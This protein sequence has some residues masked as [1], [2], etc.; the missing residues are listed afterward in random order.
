[1]AMKISQNQNIK[2]PGCGTGG[3]GLDIFSPCIIFPVLWIPCVAI[4]SRIISIEQAP[5]NPMLWICCIGALFFYLAGIFAADVYTAGIKKTARVK[6]A[7]QG[8]WNKDKFLLIMTLWLGAAVACMAYEFKYMVGG[9]PLL[10]RNW[11]IARLY[12]PEGYLS[13]LIHLFGYSFMLHAIAAQVFIYSRP[14]L[15]APGNLP[16]WAMLGADLFCAALWGS[17]HTLFIPLASGV[18]AFHYLHKRLRPSHLILLGAAAAL[19]IGAVGYIR[20]TSHFEESDVDYR[21][22]LEELGYS[23]RYPVL[24]QVHNTLAI[25]FETFRQITE[26]FPRFEPYRYGRQTFFAFYSLLPGKQESLGE[27][28]NRIWNTDFYGNL[29]ATYMG[30]PYADL[31]FIGLAVFTFLFAFFIR[32]LYLRMNRF[33]TIFNIMIYS[34]F[35]YHLILMPY[36]NTIAKLNLIFDLLILSLLNLLARQSGASPINTKGGQMS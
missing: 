29:T 26:T 16:F 19:F 11:E 1:M 25:N 9:V 7:I 24:D 35:C 33:P 10:N 2:P 6:A 36:D 5:W 13:R 18:I 23:A 15:F 21:E 14:R 20:K 28:Q 30:V 8:Q 12:S 4:G 32:H 3:S 22:V 31:G 34:Y 27:I 17:R